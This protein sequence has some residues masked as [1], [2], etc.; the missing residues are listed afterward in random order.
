MCFFGITAT[1]IALFQLVTKRMKEEYKIIS[2]VLEKMNYQEQLLVIWVDF[3]MVNFI[4]GQQRGTNAFFC[5]NAFY[6][7]R[8]VEHNMVSLRGNKYMMVGRHN[9]INEPLVLRDKIILSL[10]YLKLGL[11]KQFVKVL[12]NDS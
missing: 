2:L 5:I 8:I 10:L 4:S 7:S 3:M 1:K 11:I 6:D 9:I 12:N